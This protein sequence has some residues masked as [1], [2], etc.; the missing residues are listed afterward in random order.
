MLKKMDNYF[1]K[2]SYFNASVHFFAGLGAGAL[3]TYPLFGAHP[4]R[5]GI[6]FIVIS[7]LGHLYASKAK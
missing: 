3:V 5:W 1:G 2:H 4:V 6:T 7:I